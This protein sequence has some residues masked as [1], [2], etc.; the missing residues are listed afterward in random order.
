[1]SN[2]VNPDPTK[3][4]KAFAMSAKSFFGYLPGQTIKDFSAELKALSLADKQ[5]LA[6]LLNEEGT[7]TV[8]PEK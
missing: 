5:E 2:S 6:R 4:P 3:A 8:I 1:M 7:P